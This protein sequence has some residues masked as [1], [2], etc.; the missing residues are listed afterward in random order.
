MT[1]PHQSQDNTEDHRRLERIAWLFEQEKTGPIPP[2]QPS[3]GDVTTLNTERTILDSVG[4]EALSQMS[5]DVLALLDTSLA[6]YEKNGDYA[7]GSFVSEWCWFMDDTS[8]KLCQT[9]DNREALRCG[10]WHCHDNCWNASAKPAIDSG[11]PTDIACIGGMRLY[12]VPIFANNDVIGAVNIGYGHPPTDDAAL[13]A[14]A[15]TYGCDV[16]V[17]RQKA[18]SYQPRPPFL[19]DIAKKRLHSIALQIG[20]TVEAS[21]NAALL[22]EFPAA[23]QQR[24]RRYL[25]TAGCL[26]PTGRHST[27]IAADGVVRFYDVHRGLH[28]TDESGNARRRRGLPDHSR[29]R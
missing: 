16:D 6:V 4:Q 18:R 8:R 17:L 26:S 22:T 28:G 29:Q 13:A 20:K 11:E 5:A 15:H 2:R 25:Q 12:A 10:R 7:F 9:D 23:Y 14:L 1:Q 19:I 3:Y 27:G 21:R 24:H